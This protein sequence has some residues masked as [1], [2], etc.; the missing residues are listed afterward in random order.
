MPQR[1]AR[2]FPSLLI[3][4]LAGSMA[5]AQDGLKETFIRA[6]E[7]NRAQLRNY[8]WTR[9]T[10]IKVKG[11]S[12]DVRT[13][14]VRYDS[15]GQL[16]KTPAQHPP[17]KASSTKENRKNRTRKKASSPPFSK[18]CQISRSLIPNSRPIR[19]KP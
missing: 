5:Q 8:S 13:E 2:C 11:E 1:L 16:Q 9:R 7:Q 10:E 12:K 18:V 3:L 14:S 6:Q 19:F 4:V 15:S 17:R